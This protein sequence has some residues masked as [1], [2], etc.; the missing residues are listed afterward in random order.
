MKPE[1]DGRMMKGFAS[2]KP[3]ISKLGFGTVWLNPHRENAAVKSGIRKSVR[4]DWSF[5]L[6]LSVVAFRKLIFSL[7]VGS[8]PDLFGR[9]MCPNAHQCPA[10]FLER[11]IIVVLL[12][13][14]DRKS[15]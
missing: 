15:V 6:C 5:M 7:F 10:L 11:G 1:P 12:I 8:D 4:C 2:G 9:R 13:P 3:G 14:Q